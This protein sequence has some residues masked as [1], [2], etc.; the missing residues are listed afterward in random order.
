MA[1]SQKRVYD[2]YMVPSADPVVFLMP[3]IMPRRT[4]SETFIDLDLDLSKVAPFIRE[5]KKDIPG[6]NL[7]HIVFASLVRAAST[8]PEINRFICGN[9]LYQRENVRI[10]HFARKHTAKR[11]LG[12]RDEAQVRVLD[13]VDLRLVSAGIEAGPLEDRLFRKVRRAHRGETV[14]DQR[15]HGVHL[16]RQV[17]DD[18]LV[19]QEVEA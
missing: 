13:R 14:T 19:L 18:R 2:G 17:E 15:V 12:R 6:L 1:N 10:D 3:Y 11:D 8:V 4:D 7:Y 16:K 5:H 9:R